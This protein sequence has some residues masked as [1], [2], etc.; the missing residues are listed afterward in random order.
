MDPLSAGFTSEWLG[1]E[2][3]G[4]RRGL[5]AEG[6]TADEDAITYLVSRAGG[7]GRQI[8]TA[9]EVAIGLVLI[10]LDYCS[11]EVRAEILE[12]QTPLGRILINHNVLRRIEPTDYLRVTPGPEMMVIQPLVLRMCSVAPLRFIMLS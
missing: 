11:P 2:L 12:E 5:D 9:L 4:A 10:R 8:L 7:D 6:V 3:V 1:R